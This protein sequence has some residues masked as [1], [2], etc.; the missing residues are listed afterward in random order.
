VSV[1]VGFHIVLQLFQICE[2]VYNFVSGRPDRL[3]RLDGRAD[4]IRRFF[5]ERS[6]WTRICTQ[7]GVT[8]ATSTSSHTQKP[9]SSMPIH[10]HV[11]IIIPCIRSRLWSHVNCVTNRDV[12]YH[13]LMENS[14][15]I[16]RHPWM[17]VYLTGIMRA[18]AFAA[19]V[20]AV[21]VLALD[22]SS[23]SLL[24]SQFPFL[25]VPSQLLVEWSFHRHRLLLFCWSRSVIKCLGNV[26]A[27]THT[28]L[29]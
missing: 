28:K 11:H 8:W 3:S 12:Q 1:Q 13:P 4:Q 9:T 15:M 21:C 23:F 27:P 17:F 26:H 10:S 29:N 7:S 25:S 20:F 24:F 19:I 2:R 18:V 6:Q 16:Q 14:T 22:F 5:Q